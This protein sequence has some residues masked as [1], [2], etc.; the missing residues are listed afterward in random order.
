[1]SSLTNQDFED[2]LV[3]DTSLKIVVDDSIERSL[4]EKTLMHESI[5]AA[6]KVLDHSNRAAVI[7]DAHDTYVKLLAYAG[8]PPHDKHSGGVTAFSKYI[9]WVRQVAV[10]V[11]TLFPGLAQKEVY[12]KTKLYADWC[13][14]QRR[15][16]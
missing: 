13:R 8:P 10:G 14:Q 4:S 15:K 5:V 2:D 7:I 1:M 6:A 11:R 12:E 9:K 3:H 16:S